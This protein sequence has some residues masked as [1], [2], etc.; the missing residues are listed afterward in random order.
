MNQVIAAYGILLIAA[1]TFAI[2]VL[3]GTEGFTRTGP[4]LLCLGGFVVTAWSLARLVHTGMQLSILMPLAAAIIPLATIAVGVV[5][6]GES[7]SVTK[8]G[9]LV[10]ACALIG[11]AARV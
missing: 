10:T 6:Y 11:V 3:P 2:A 5:L 8:L 1:N 7:A 4:T 9:L